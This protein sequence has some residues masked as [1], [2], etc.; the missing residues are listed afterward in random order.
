MPA[1]AVEAGRGQHRH[2]Q[3]QLRAQPSDRIA[4]EDRQMAQPVRPAALEV[5]Q[6][7][8]EQDHQREVDAGLPAQPAGQHRHRAEHAERHH[9]RAEVG[10]DV[11]RAGAGPQVVAGEAL[12]KRRGQ[13][14]VLRRVGEESAVPIGQIHF[15]Q[16]LP[17]ERQQLERG[18]PDA[19]R[20]GQRQRQ[21]VPD[22]AD[23]PRGARLPHRAS[24]WRSPGPG[25]TRRPGRR[26][27]RPPPGSRR[28]AAAPRPA[29]PAPGW[30]SGVPARTARWRRT[31][32]GSR[33]PP[34]PAASSSRRS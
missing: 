28:T 12:R 17:D 7:D 18:Q 34:R 19:Q 16:E 14:V 4:L 22:R 2:R 25:R 5:G 1:Q 23:Q 30:P 20:R 26:S 9:R 27:G 6:P 21:H 11:H 32:S 15:L 13:Q 33:R 24:A 8:H 29:R 10:V 31:S 3:T